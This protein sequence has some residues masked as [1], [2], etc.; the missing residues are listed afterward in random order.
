M[1][2]GDAILAEVYGGQSTSHASA[3]RTAKEPRRWGTPPLSF[4]EY[5]EKH[6]GLDGKGGCYV[7]YGQNRD[8]Y[9]DH[10]RCEM[11][12]REKAQYFHCIPEKV[13][14]RD[15]RGG[16]DPRQHRQI[17]ADGERYAQLIVEI[18]E[19]RNQL[20]TS[21]PQWQ[22]VSTNG[23]PLLSISGELPGHTWDCVRKRT[24]CG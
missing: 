15:Q 22:R 20:A 9:H 4:G 7:C 2:A 5:R 1:Q 12:K 18:Q 13:P 17:S 8:H 6:G 24:G 19:L 16:C 23:D 10:A 14:Q 11:N 21:Q 3:A